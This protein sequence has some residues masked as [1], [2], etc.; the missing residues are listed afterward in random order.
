MFHKAF[1]SKYI[2]VF[3]GVLYS[4]LA[5]ILFFSIS[6]MQSR[7]DGD[8]LG[9]IQPMEYFE[10]QGSFQP[11]GQTLC[12]NIMSIGYPL[13]LV[14]TRMLFGENYYSI[15]FVQFIL[16]LLCIFLVFK[17]AKLF[18]SETIAL[19]SSVLASINLA[20]I[21]Y[22]HFFLTEMLSMFVLL[23]ALERLCHYFVYGRYFPVM[24]S[25]LLFGA[26]V[27]VKGA[28]LYYVFFLM[29]LMVFDLKKEFSTRFK[30]VALFLL[31]FAI[32]IGGYMVRNKN[33]YG[34]WHFQSLSSFNIYNVFL[35]KIIK[36]DE[37]LSDAQ[38]NQRMHDL[39]SSVREYASGE[40]WGEARVV[41]WEKVSKS[42]MVVAKIWFLNVMKTYL[43]LFTNHLKVVLY[44]NIA[45]GD[46]SFFK[47]SGTL[48]ERAWKYLTF[49]TSS[50][51]IVGLG[52]VEV[53]WNVLRYVFVLIALVYLLIYRKWLEFILFGSWIAYFPLLTGFDGCGRYRSMIEMQ[54]L[55]LGV[56]GFMIT[57][58]IV[59]KKKIS[60]FTYE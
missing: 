55:V 31:C 53:F 9:Y 57:W 14:I 39:L 19:I 5:L 33:I 58:N 11:K 26:S 52:I 47:F 49:G 6:S 40:G 24:L 60:V 20:L 30:A 18:F 16:A 59:F 38:V 21:L 29:F 51:F 8:S 27:V 50:K 37:H 43:G 54:L 12:K 10:Q 48:F 3:S 28:A 22:P 4:V 35:S 13:F 25:G 15:I 32:P 34:Y 17:L 2:L 56:V 45:G 44:E 7:F 41:F 46:C 36:E 23:Y 42:P 1:S